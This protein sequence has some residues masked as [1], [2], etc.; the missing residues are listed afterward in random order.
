MLKSLYKNSIKF[1]GKEP[2]SALSIIAIILFD[3]VLFTVI[4]QALKHHPFSTPYFNNCEYEMKSFV[5]DNGR[6]IDVLDIAV[7][8]LKSDDFRYSNDKETNSICKNYYEFKKELR[9]SDKIKSLLLEHENNIRLRDIAYKRKKKYTNVMIDNNMT[10]D[11]RQVIEDI[12]KYEGK[13][14]EIDANLRMS[15]EAMRL[16]EYAQE[17][18]PVL[19]KQQDKA[20]RFFRAKVALYQLAFLIPL[21][22]LANIYNNKCQKQKSSIRVLILSNFQ[23]VI[24]VFFIITFF[25]LLSSIIPN[26]LF[27]NLFKL[28]SKLGITFIWYYIVIF[29]ALIMFLGIIYYTQLKTEYKRYYKRIT[30]NRC[31]ECGS[32]LMGAPTCFSCGK[33]QF[34]ICPECKK[35]TYDKM[36]YCSNCGHK[37]SENL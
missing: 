28:F 32:K 18:Y 22:F 23:I 17:N 2:L 19:K 30:K 24:G 8:K 13:L 14:E 29:I 20:K 37:L 6:I 27:K 16:V 1:N 25:S 10:A 12:S 35:E 9:A 26:H 5:S 15:D 7:Q 31:I 3:L 34:I 33:K 36:P 11:T 4:S 21:F